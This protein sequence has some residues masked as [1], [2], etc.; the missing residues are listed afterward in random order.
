MEYEEI[1]LELTVASI[2]WIQVQ[3]NITFEESIDQLGDKV[4][5]L[6]KKL[7]KAVEEEG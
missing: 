5:K 2:E 6:Y 4:A 3:E 7:L 1:A